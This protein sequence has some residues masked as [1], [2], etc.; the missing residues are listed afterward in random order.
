MDLS[1]LCKSYNFQIESDMTISD[2][3]PETGKLAFS[4]GTIDGFVLPSTIIHEPCGIC[5]AAL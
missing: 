5:E 4:H 3:I 2:S 1:S